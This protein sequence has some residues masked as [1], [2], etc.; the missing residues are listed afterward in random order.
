MKKATILIA[1]LTLA[2]TISNAQELTLKEVIVGNEGNFGSA[3]ATVTQYDF[4]NK[5][6]TDGVF[7]NANGVG[8][9]DVVQSITEIDNELYIVVNNSQKIVIVN[10]ETFQQTGQISFGVGASPREIVALGNGQ[11]YVTD[12]FGN[13]INIV[14]LSTKQVLADTIRVGRNPDKMLKL[15]DHV[16]VSNNGFGADST[17]FKVDISSNSVVDTIIVNRGPASMVEGLNNT[18]WVVSQGYAGDFDQD[19]NIIPGTDEPGGV[20]GFESENGA[21]FASRDI[22]SVGEDI[23]ISKDK[24]NVY[25]NSGGIQEISV[26]NFLSFERDTL[27]RGNFYSFSFDAEGDRFFVSD[28]KTFTS[29]GEVRYYNSSGNL[30]GSFDTGIIPGDLYLSYEMTTSAQLESGEHVENFRLSQ[31]YPNPFNP[32]T[33]INFSVPE[34]GRVKLEVFNMQGQLVATLLNGN[35]VKGDHSVTFN[36]ESLSSGL[37]VYRLTNENS[38]IAKKMTLIK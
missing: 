4:L 6:A 26:L 10:P 29:A 24:Q 15:N 16:F 7:L 14:D 22:D 17:I 31:N 2:G 3:N 20:F 34:N 25:I 13:Y 27:I 18:I 12:L 33:S 11:A 28:A 9:G 8:L 37:Y 23:G 35:L 5:T 38:S 21:I 1:I 30:Q 19:F 32:S 36:A